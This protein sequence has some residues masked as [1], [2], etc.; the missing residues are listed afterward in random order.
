MSGVFTWG[1]PTLRDTPDLCPSEAEYS[2]Q[3][4]HI[5]LKVRL[6]YLTKE[7]FFF[8]VRHTGLLTRA[9]SFIFLQYTPGNRADCCS[10]I[11][12]RLNLCVAEGSSVSPCVNTVVGKYL[13][14]ICLAEHFN[15]AVE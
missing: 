12:C 2:K 1:I 14:S 5:D 13:G 7:L 4:C 11:Y 9:H 6:I 15:G 8:A 3:K 10:L